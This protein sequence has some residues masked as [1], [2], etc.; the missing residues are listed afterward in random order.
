[1]VRPNKAAWK[2]IIVQAVARHVLSIN[3]TVG[4]PGCARH[5]G[6]SEILAICAR[7]RIALCAILRDVR[8]S[9]KRPTRMVVDPSPHIG[10][11]PRPSLLLRRRNRSVTIGR[12]HQPVAIPIKRLIVPPSDDATMPLAIYQ[13][14]LAHSIEVMRRQRAWARNI[15]CAIDI[16]RL[17]QTQA[18]IAYAA[19]PTIAVI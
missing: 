10:V 5:R 13:A 8:P 14:A 12:R 19:I 18:D 16:G 6:A 7:A 1:L 9:A 3:W 17:P 15:K 2:P 4:K 11:S